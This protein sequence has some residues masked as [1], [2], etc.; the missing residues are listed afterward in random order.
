MATRLKKTNLQHSCILRSIPRHI[1]SREPPRRSGYYKHTWYGAI[2]ITPFWIPLL[3]HVLQTSVPEMSL[4]QFGFSRRSGDVGER[5][6][7]G[8]KEDDERQTDRSTSDVSN[9]ETVI[10][11]G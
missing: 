4:F 1:G 11:F 7:E 8:E 10:H 9:Y 3:T 2:R 5:G 6:V